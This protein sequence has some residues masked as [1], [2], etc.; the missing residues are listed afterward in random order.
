[1]ND[2]QF[3]N[4][5]TLMLSKNP[6]TRLCKISHIKAHPWLSNFSW[7]S[8]ISLDLQPPYVPKVKSKEDD[9]NSMPY[10]SFLKVLLDIKLL[11]SFIKFKFEII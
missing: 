6:L 11:K 9:F 1:M 5:I 3:K 10:V 4:L 8:L 2:N 7:D